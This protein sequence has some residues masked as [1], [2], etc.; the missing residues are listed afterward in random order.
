MTLIPPHTPKARMLL[1]VALFLATPLL[2][3]CTVPGPLGG[4]ER[5][6]DAHDIVQRGLEHLADIAHED[7]GVPAWP[8]GGPDPKTTMWVLVAAAL[9]RRAGHEGVFDAG[10]HTAYLKAHT[11]RLPVETT[12]IDSAANNMSL[13]RAAFV[14]WG[15]DPGGI[16]IDDPDHPDV[17]TVE[18]AWQARYDNGTGRYGTRP[19]EHVFG[20]WAALLFAPGTDIRHKMADYTGNATTNPALAKQGPEL[21]TNDAWYAAHARIALGPAPARHG[22][23]T[24]LAATLDQALDDHHDP[25]TGGVRGFVT[26]DTPDASSTAAALIAWTLQAQADIPADTPGDELPTI[27]HTARGQA[28]TEF[29][30]SLQQ[31][32]GEIRFSIDRRFAP[33]KT[34]AEVVMGLAFAEQPIP[35]GA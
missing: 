31:S 7:G 33:T 29:L 32:D 12:P 5:A 28:A 10:P 34:T 16:R 6:C 17:V 23:N 19:N 13:A 11:G 27:L 30:C 26:S 1:L 20:A 25:K 4:T 15:K 2:A 8:D 35:W 14:T 24:T 18:Q 22:A 9:A 21:Y 3:G